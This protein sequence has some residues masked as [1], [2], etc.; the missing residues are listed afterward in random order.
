MVIVL[1]ILLAIAVAFIFCLILMLKKAF[2]TIYCLLG[3]D[4]KSIKLSHKV[5]YNGKYYPA[6]VI[7]QVIF[8]AKEWQTITDFSMYEDKEIIC[9]TLYTTENIKQYC[10]GNE[11]LEAAFGKPMVV[12]HAVVYEIEE[13]VWT[14]KSI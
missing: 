6:T 9:Y 7:T 5:A 14:W 3:K 12:P 8:N 4:N 11:A 2:K 10:E 1:S 13:G